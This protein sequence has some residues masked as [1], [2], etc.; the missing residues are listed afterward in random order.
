MKQDVAVRACANL[1]PNKWRCP[2]RLVEWQPDQGVTEDPC[3][4][5]GRN[6]VGN[7]FG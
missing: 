3:G 6:V 4:K 7:W 5:L 2:I 1:T